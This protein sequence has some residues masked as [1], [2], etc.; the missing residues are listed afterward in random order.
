MQSASGDQ[1][2]LNIE[3]VVDGGVAGE[4]DGF[5]SLRR[6]F[7]SLHPLQ[8]PSMPIKRLAAAV[9]RGHRASEEIRN[10]AFGFG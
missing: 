6:G 3:C 5:P 7:D 9:A 4:E 8:L 10:P 1:V 2:M